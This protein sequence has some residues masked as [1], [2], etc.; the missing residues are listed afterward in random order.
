VDQGDLLHGVYEQPTHFRFFESASVG[1]FH[2]HQRLVFH[3]KLA[4]ACQ[5]VMPKPDLYGGTP[6]DHCA[7][8]LQNP[9]P[10]LQ[11]TLQRKIKH[12]GVIDHVFEREPV[13]RNHNSALLLQVVGLVGVDQVEKIVGIVRRVH[14]VPH[15]VEGFRG[16]MKM[17]VLF[18]P[19]HKF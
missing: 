12:L 9:V 11:R 2:Q 13:S 14:F 17:H 3:N 18:L 16:A 10:P 1:L 7:T 8:R 19:V 4:G 15:I 5:R 6:N